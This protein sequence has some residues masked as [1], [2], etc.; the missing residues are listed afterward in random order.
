MY[1]GI[2]FLGVEGRR[3]RYPMEQESVLE[4]GKPN[5]KIFL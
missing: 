5:L 1:I 2:S 4:E 3:R